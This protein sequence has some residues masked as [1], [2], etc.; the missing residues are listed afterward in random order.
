MRFDREI[1]FLTA[2]IERLYQELDRRELLS[3]ERGGLPKT[4][5]E[6][7]GRFKNLAIRIEDITPENFKDKMAQEFVK[8]AKQAREMVERAEKIRKRKMRKRVIS[9]WVRFKR[10]I[11]ANIPKP[12]VK[13][14]SVLSPV[15]GADKKQIGW[16]NDTKKVVDWEM[17]VWR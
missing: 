14:K 4:D 8:K 17:E 1:E 13:E 6:L 12:T 15:Y 2:Q 11:I 10:E 5:K 16:V 9:P 7:W 3:E